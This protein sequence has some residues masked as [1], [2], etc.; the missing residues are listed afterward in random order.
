MTKD[1]KSLSDAPEYQAKIYEFK[2]SEVNT[3]LKSFLLNFPNLNCLI[4]I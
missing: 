3:K 4:K 1:P 2:L